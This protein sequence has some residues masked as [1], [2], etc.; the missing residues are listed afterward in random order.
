MTIPVSSPIVVTVTPQASPAVN[1]NTI[2][3]GPI[4]QPN[5]AYTHTQGT[6]S[7]TWVINHYLGW[8]PNVT[9]QDSAGTTVEGNISYTNNN[10]LSITFSGAF[11]GKAYL[12]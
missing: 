6:S 10:S 8:N 9:V 7:A 1:L 4:N 12:S 3:V 11:S 5:V 2:T